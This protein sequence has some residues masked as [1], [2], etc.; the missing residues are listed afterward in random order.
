VCWNI[1]Q[2]SLWLLCNVHF[3]QSMQMTRL[4]DLADLKPQ[5]IA[6]VKN[7]N[8]PMLTHMW[9]ELKYRIDVCCVTH[10]DG[11]HIGTSPVVKK[12]KNQF[13]CGCVQFH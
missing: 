4:Q 7:I 9:Q 13:S 3:K 11:V 8:A 5:I 12:K 2:V 1:T 6:A 10:G